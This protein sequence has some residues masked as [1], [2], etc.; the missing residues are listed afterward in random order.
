MGMGMGMGMGGGA[1][2]PRDGHGSSRTSGWAW[3]QQGSSMGA[4]P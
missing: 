4:P 3:E 1:A 2:G